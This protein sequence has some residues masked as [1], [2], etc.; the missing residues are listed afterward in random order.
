MGSAAPRKRLDLLLDVFARVRR[1]VPDLTLVQ[2][3]AAFGPDLRAQADRLDLSSA[4][5]QPPPLPRAELAA[6]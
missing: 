1:E 4:L 5:V 6:L 2:V 3:G